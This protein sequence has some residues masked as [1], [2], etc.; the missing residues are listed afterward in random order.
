L[1]LVKWWLL[2]IP[3]YLIVGVLV[4]GTR[5]A[6]TA[7]GQ[8]VDIPVAG[9]NSWL[10]LVAVVALLV[11]GRYP[12]GIFN[13]LVGLNRWIFRVIAYVALFTDDY[14]PFRLDQGPDEPAA[15]PAAE[16]TPERAVASE[17]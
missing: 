4:G 8:S 5:T 7:N 3:Q 16:G 14:P 6:W 15:P 11:T 13:L 1:V 9:L 10:V 2:A 17:P 12:T